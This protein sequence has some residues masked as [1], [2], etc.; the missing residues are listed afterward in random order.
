MD[1][2]SVATQLQLDSAVVESH[3]HHVGSMSHDL[4]DF[5]PKN[6]HHSLCQVEE[7]FL[8]LHNVLGSVSVVY[9]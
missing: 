4:W 8:F 6:L 9:E 5:H 2:L 1:S 7:G 3:F